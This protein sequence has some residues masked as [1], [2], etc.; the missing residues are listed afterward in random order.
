ML[1]EYLFHFLQRLCSGCL[2]RT[3]HNMKS[4]SNL[5]VSP[6]AKIGKQNDLPFSS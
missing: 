3:S 2:Y 5:L 1:F 4:F 6:I